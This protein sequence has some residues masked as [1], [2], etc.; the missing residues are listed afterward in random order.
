M[1]YTFFLALAGTVSS[2]I[3]PPFPFPSNSCP[4]NTS[5]VQTTNGTVCG[6]SLPSRSQDLFLGIPFAQPPVGKLRFA[7]PQPVSSRYNN[8]KATSQPASCIGYGDFS[9]TV[10]GPLSEDCLYLNIVRPR[11]TAGA[12][13]VLVWIYGG[14]FNAGG[15]ADERYNTTA[16]VELSVKMKKPTIIV[17]INYRLSGW[18]F[19]ASRE[20]L[21]SGAGNAGL[22]DQRLALRWI[23]DNIRAFGGDPEAVTIWG[24]SAGAMSV[25]YHTVAFDGEHANL[26]RA[27]IMESGTAMGRPTAST[28]QI[29]QK[30]GLQSFFDEAV[31]NTG[32]E[33][34]I[35][36]LGCLREA[37][38]DALNKTFANQFYWPVI[39]GDFIRRRP[40]E[41][42]AKGLAA[43]VALLIG[44]NTDE[45]TLVGF[46]PRGTLNSDKDVHDWIQMIGPELSEDQITRLLELYPDDPALGSP[47]NTG[48]QRYESQ[49]H[50][51]KRGA[52][53]AGDLGV[54]LGRRATAEQYAVWS[55]DDHQPVYSYRF[56][57]R[58]WNGTLT[59]VATDEPVGVTHFTEVSEKCP[60]LS[61][62][63]ADRR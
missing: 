41:S 1:R 24:E 8:L 59:S 61:T 32:C 58:P 35:D 27:A 56:D 14:G 31:K 18:G 23:R 40:S 4:P 26:F 57:Q 13:P 43:K 42:Y 53:I 55:D 22:F 11:T 36:A 15:L 30:G 20:V 21:D 63:L 10:G 44:A 34:G 6:V 25:G 38:F 48:T 45:G 16:L 37:P 46:G 49:G 62:I 7:H 17:S 3:A 51:Y 2:T 50:Q 19:L 28:E 12:L 9:S 33:N 52:A 60:F 29:Q 39:D 5:S 47:F 54:I